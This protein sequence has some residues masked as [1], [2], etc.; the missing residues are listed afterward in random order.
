M[1]SIDDSVVTIQTSSLPVPS[2][3]SWFGEV[4]LMAAHLRKHDV[5]TKIAERVRVARRRF[6]RYEGAT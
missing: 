4:V 5:L 3:P 6:G 1:S 2:T